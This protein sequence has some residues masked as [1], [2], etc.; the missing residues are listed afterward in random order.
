MHIE[1]IHG[2]KMPTRGSVGSAGW[3]LYARTRALVPA[4]RLE[5]VRVGIITS[6]NPSLVGLIRDRSG[7]AVKG[8]TTRAG[9][10][11]SDYRQEWGVVLANE[12]DTDYFVEVGDRIAQVVF[13]PLAPVGWEQSLEVRGGGF[14]STGR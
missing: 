11:D 3:D 8:I 5:L 6:F 4:R 12:T 2:G 14:G 10:I 1:L 13:L 7:L 9:V